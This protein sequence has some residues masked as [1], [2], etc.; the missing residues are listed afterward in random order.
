VV[1]HKRAP[2]RG[3]TWEGL[4]TGRI[5]A[6][7]VHVGDGVYLGSGEF[8]GLEFNEHLY[9]GPGANTSEADAF[10]VTGHIHPVAVDGWEL[11]LSFPAART[12]ETVGA[13][14][15]AWSIGDGDAALELYASDAVYVNTDG[16]TTEGGADIASLVASA[17][18][19]GEVELLPPLFVRGNYA[20]G[21]FRWTNDADEGW[22]LAVLRIDEAGL[23]AH[24]EVIGE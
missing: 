2:T 7:S 19:A 16:S 11:D 17:A 21:A 23:I 9:M 24:H 13:V 22:V 8:A 1:A 3:G 10:E 12:R 20:V 4:N 15:R 6:D 14:A 5:E 18:D